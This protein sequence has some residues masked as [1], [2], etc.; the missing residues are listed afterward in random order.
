MVHISYML[1]M[2]CVLNSPLRMQHVKAP[3]EEWGR[4]LWS[5]YA[6]GFSLYNCAQIIFLRKKNRNFESC[7]DGKVV[8]WL[9]LMNSVFVKWLK[10]VTITKLPF[11]YKCI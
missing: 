6:W 1:I 10:C 3:E 2:D 8:K 11:K 9:K 4:L 5:Y 7:F